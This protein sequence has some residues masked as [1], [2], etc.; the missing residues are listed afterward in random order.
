MKLQARYLLPSGIG[1]QNQNDHVHTSHKGGKLI[2][3]PKSLHQGPLTSD[4]R[5]DRGKT[6]L[7]LHRTMLCLVVPQLSSR[8]VLEEP[9]GRNLILGGCDFTRTPLWRRERCGVQGGMKGLEQI[10][11]SSHVYTA[12]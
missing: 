2:L 4:L 3:A 12:S 6:L 9:K 5:G 10:E 8:C 1:S 11:P 7:H